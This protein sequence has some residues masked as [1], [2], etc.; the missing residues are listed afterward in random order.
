MST[1]DEWVAEMWYTHTMEHYL[2]I[3]GNEELIHA[4]IQMN[5]EKIMLLKEVSHKGIC[6]V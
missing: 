3:K 6:I 1:A 2:A 4:T 5:L